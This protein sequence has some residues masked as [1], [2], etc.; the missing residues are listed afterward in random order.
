MKMGK[1]LVLGFILLSIW[2]LF[3]VL[4]DA[5]NFLGNIF[6]ILEGMFV[7]TTVSFTVFYII[8]KVEGENETNSKR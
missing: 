1:G 3:T 4:A 6:S 2:F 5:N 8:E 7:G